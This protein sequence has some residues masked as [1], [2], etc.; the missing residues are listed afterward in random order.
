MRIA[1]YLHRQ[2]LSSGIESRFA[3]GWGEKGGDTPAEL[4]VR[5]VFR[6]GS[7]FRWLPIWRFTH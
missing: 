4:S 5:I 7:D 2:L 1:F 3:Y 6:W